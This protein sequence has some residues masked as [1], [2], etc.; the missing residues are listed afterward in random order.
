MSPIVIGIIV[1]AVLILIPMALKI[2][3]EYQRGVIFRIGRLVGTKGP[4]LLFIIPL[5]DRMVKV[6]LRMVT[7]DM[8]SQE[9]ITKDNV[10]VRVD[11]VVR[12]KVV[13]PV[14]ATIK[15][16]DHIR[17][18][19]EVSQDTLHN[20]L[21]Q[22]A[23][24]ELVHVDELNKTL[25][26]SIDRQTRAWGVEVTEVELKRMYYGENYR[27]GVCGKEVPVTKVG[28][29]TLSCCSHEMGVI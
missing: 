9:A 10:T 5:I 22:S 7:M 18:T 25:Q 2:L 23:R 19:S 3:P 26:G 29:G 14:A 13:D 27:C 8:P 12:F 6:D 28:E 15:T 1:L 21:I 24:D 20:L 16:L 4:G 11:A 17:A